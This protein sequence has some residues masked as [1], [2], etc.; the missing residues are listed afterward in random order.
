MQSEA[1]L[2]EYRRMTPAERLQLTFELIEEG[3][4]YL[5]LGT[6]AQVQRKRQRIRQQ[7]DLSNRRML[8]AFAKLKKVVP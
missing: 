6:E 1:K 7:N 4:R 5:S 8:E 3:W 2:E